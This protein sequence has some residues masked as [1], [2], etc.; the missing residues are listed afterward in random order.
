MAE[1]GPPELTSHPTI[2]PTLLSFDK[3]NRKYNISSSP[4]PLTPLLKNPIFPPGL[5]SHPLSGRQ[6]LIGLQLHHILEKGELQDREHINAH[7]ASKQLD[8]FS[9]MQIKHLINSIKTQTD[10]SPDLPP[11][12][13]LCTNG[14]PHRHVI[15][16]LHNM[17]WDTQHIH[18]LFRVYP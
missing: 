1:K 12:D 17:L 5:S 6:P 10:L 2:G 9:Y 18:I 4:G 16:L 13:S 11:F 8:F 3:A 14:K 7:L 15:S